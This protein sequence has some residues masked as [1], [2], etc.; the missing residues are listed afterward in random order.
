[1]KT[2]T[3]KQGKVECTDITLTE[4]MLRKWKSTVLLVGT[5]YGYNFCLSAVIEFHRFLSFITALK[6]F[7][8]MSASKCFV[9]Y[10]D[11]VNMGPSIYD[12]HTEGGEG[13]RAQVD[14]CGREEGDPAPCGRPH[15]K[16]K[17]ESTDVVL[18][19]SQAKKLA[20]FSPKFRLWTHSK[21][22]YVRA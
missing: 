14:A 12:V 21:N 13:G 16:L 7:A 17:L 11:S 10:I 6:Q 3:G 20:S 1:M 5:L 19:S 15:R 8:A 4:S 9:K 22:Y 18:S 2:M